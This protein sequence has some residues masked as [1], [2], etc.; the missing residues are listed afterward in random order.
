MEEARLLLTA[1]RCTMYVCDHSKKQLWSTVAEGYKGV[2]RMPIGVG[3]AGNCARYGK[4]INVKDAAHDTRVNNVGD[5][6]PRHILC[7]PIIDRRL[8]SNTGNAG[9]RTRRTSVGGH[10]ANT[11]SLLKR[12]RSS[13]TYRTAEDDEDNEIDESV[14]G[15]VQV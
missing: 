2:I 12:R 8:V 11:D 4:P 7:V 9:Q 10:E 3:I 5:F 13:G 14:I 15:V 6:R 1:E